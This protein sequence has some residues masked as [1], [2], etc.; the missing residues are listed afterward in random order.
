ME[1]LYR[2]IM[3]IWMVTLSL[4]LAGT[5]R[6]DLISAAEI[7]H[8]E[9]TFEDWTAKIIRNVQP[10]AEFTV[11][12]RVELSAHPERL[13][14]YEE[15]KAAH[16]LPGLPEVSDPNYSNP[17]DSPLLPLLEKKNIKVYFRTVLNRDQE[18]IIREVVQAK[19]KI[20]SADSLMF[21]TTSLSSPKPIPS[22][23]RIYGVLTLCAGMILIALAMSGS[24]GRKSL[25]S[26]MATAAQSVSK[27]SRAGA[28]HTSS[29]APIGISPSLQISNANASALREALAQ[30]KVEV[31][32]KASMHAT[33]RFS[34]QVLG[35]MDQPKFDLVNQ[36]IE[37]NK[38]QVS[39]GDAAYAR[40]IL[41][42]RLQ[43]I[44]N[45]NLLKSIEGYSKIKKLRKKI[46][47]SGNKLDMIQEVREVVA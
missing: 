9:Q 16:H 42:A 29:V 47:A 18:R 39:T 32:A 35:E 13:N 5:A 41:A 11:V 23:N 38:S 7:Q 33:R 25:S 19:M 46:E 45:Q 6:A 17:L 8:F 28:T 36:W 43:Q 27:A 31:I 2:K 4:T 3:F 37:R 14:A 15:A 1:T 10:K 12:A 24:K 26:I 21:E 20:S 40:L 44:N 22:R 30:E 34:A